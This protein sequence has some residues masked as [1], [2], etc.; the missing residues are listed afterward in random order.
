LNI[1]NLKYP[2]G[3][4]Q[5]PILYTDVIRNEFK[6]QVRL[7]PEKLNNLV[8]GFSSEQI[9]VPYRPGG[10]SSQQVVH[11][12]ADSHMNALIRIKLALTESV[13]TIKAYKEAKWAELLDYDQDCS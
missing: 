2:I 9:L 4:C 1:E 6:E 3:R 8:E 12:L 7:F 10:W 5:Y 11:H 13:P